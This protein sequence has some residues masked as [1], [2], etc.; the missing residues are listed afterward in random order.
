MRGSCVVDDDGYGCTCQADGEGDRLATIP[1]NKDVEVCKP[2]GSQG[3]VRYFSH[4]G[5]VYGVW[6]RHVGIFEVFAAK[7]CSDVKAR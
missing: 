4:L 7:R 2:E 1:F 6:L 5:V 3:F